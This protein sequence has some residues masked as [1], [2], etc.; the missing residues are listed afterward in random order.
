MLLNTKSYFKIQNDFLIQHTFNQNINKKIL[1]INPDHVE[2]KLSL[3]QIE[4]L[5]WD[6]PLNDFEL[7]Q[8]LTNK[9]GPIY[10][11]LLKKITTHIKKSSYMDFVNKYL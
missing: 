3:Y 8:E 10:L 1:I 7:N 6:K 2:N 4:S 5:S 9:D 11:S